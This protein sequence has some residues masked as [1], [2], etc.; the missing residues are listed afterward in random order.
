MIP[1]FVDTA[2]L[3]VPVDYYEN[4]FFVEQCPRV[5][6]LVSTSGT[7]GA[8]GNNMLTSLLTEA[9]NDD[10]TCLGLDRGPP[11]LES[12]EAFFKAQVQL[13]AL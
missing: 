6:R 3:Q 7:L 8:L 10:G 13:A 4:D 12:S 1:V 9:T 5:F 11:G 2:C